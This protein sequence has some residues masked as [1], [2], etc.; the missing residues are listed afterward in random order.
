[1]T[2]SKYIPEEME[3][4]AGYVPAK[5]QLHHVHF[6]A[7]TTADVQVTEIGE[8]VLFN[9]TR[10]IMVFGLWTQVEEAFTAS[11]TATVG[12]S[13][14]IDRF[15]NSGTVAPQST[16]A[17]LVASTGLTVPYFY[18][19]GQDIKVGIGAATVAAGLASVYLQYAIVED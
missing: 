1:M 18:A 14:T 13:T 12:D 19:A 3:Q 4:F 5:M 8:Y 2:D 10:P 15:I 17:V 11:V 16:G 9:V 6:G 7:A